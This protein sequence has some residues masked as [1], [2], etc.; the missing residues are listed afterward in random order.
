MFLGCPAPFYTAHARLRASV[1]FTMT[2]HGLNKMVLHTHY[3]REEFSSTK[4]N[5]IIMM[6]HFLFVYVD[7]KE[8]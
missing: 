8:F 7:S 6:T 1:N 4:L 3:L 5:I 2:E